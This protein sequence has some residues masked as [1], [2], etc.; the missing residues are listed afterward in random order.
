MTD[1]D[2]VAEALDKVVVNIGQIDHQS[3]LA[4]ERA[5]RAGRLTKWRG[6]WHPVAGASWGLG[7]PKT[8]YGTHEMAALVSAA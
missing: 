7:S 6:F 3:K 5:V 4:L 1:R 8:C 2:F